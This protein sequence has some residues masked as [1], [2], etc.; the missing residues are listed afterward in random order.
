MKILLGIIVLGAL[1]YGIYVKYPSQAT[2]KQPTGVRIGATVEEVEKVL[3][4][5]SRVLPQFGRQS[6][7][8]KGESGKT[9]ML[10]FEGGELVEI[11]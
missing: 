11:H 3:G 7:F 5:P 4:R 10:V 8:Y 2:P 1:G 6:R 9:Y